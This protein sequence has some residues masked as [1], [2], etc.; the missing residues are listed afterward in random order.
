[1]SENLLFLLSGLLI[2]APIIAYLIN[3]KYFY[4]SLIILYPV[5]GQLIDIK[6]TILGLALNPSMIF[7]LVVLAFTALDFFMLPS[8]QRVLEVSIVMFITYLMASAFFSPTRGDS[9]SW[10]MKIATWLLM[11]AVST[12]LFTEKQDLIQLFFVTSVAV[13][14]VILSFT[15]SKLGYYGKSITY[16]TGVKLYGGGFK[17]GKSMAYYLAIALPVLAIVGLDK[18]QVAR[19][20]AWLLAVVSL[21]VIVLTFVRSPIIALLVGFMVFQYFS[22]RYVQKDLKKMVVWLV[23]IA[24]IIVAAF[25]FLEDSEYTS[26]W[27]ELGDKY[28]AGKVEKLGS[29]R[30]GGLM[31]FYEYYIHKASLPKKIFGSGFGASH[32]F[33]G[34]GV[35]IHNDFAEIILGCGVIGIALYMMIF[36]C[37]FRSLRGLLQKRFLKEFHLPVIL[38]L[39]SFFMLLSFH[40]TNISSGVFILSVW[41][42]HVGATVGIGDRLARSSDAAIRVELR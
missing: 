9:I 24:V 1:M 5:I 7:G 41:S 13:M 4:Y 26:R 2:L 10:S 6:V 28:S 35:L 11:L 14:I 23:A 19:P 22:A 32:V 31:G 29:G 25:Y 40:M 21:A 8:R 38:A 39:C 12:K 30:I 17:S 16:E 37:L 36:V 18:R 20:L 3:R 15:F 33:L 42:M 27:R 34:T